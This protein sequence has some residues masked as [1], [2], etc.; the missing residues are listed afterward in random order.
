MKAYLAE[1]TEE[2]GISSKTYAQARAFY[3]E[4]LRQYAATGAAAGKKAV[5]FIHEFNL[6]IDEVKGRRVNVL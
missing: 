2:A 6:C 3:T 4:F 5:G 1:Y